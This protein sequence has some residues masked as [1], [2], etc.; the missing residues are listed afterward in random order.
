LLLVELKEISEYIGQLESE[1]EVLI[2]DRARYER[3]LEHYEQTVA[4]YGY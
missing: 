4:A 2:V 3:D 1:I